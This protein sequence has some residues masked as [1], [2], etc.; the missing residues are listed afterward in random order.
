[1]DLMRRIGVGSELMV[2]FL[3]PHDEALAQDLT[4]AW[5]ET[6]SAA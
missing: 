6:G 3:L 5:N 4:A 1:M 2:G